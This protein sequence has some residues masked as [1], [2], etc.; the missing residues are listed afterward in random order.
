MSRFAK[1]FVA[2]LTAF[3]VVVS[4]PGLRSI[5]FGSN[6]HALTTA[7]V[8]GVDQPVSGNFDSAAQSVTFDLVSSPTNGTVNFDA[9]SGDFTY[10]PTSGFIGTDTFLFSET[11]SDPSVAPVTGDV[12]IDVLPAPTAIPGALSASPG[13]TVFSASLTTSGSFGSGVNL[14][15]CLVDPVTN[16]CGTSVAL[17]DATYSLDNSTG[18]VT[19][20][21]SPLATFG[22]L[23]DVTYIVTDAAG[24]SATSVISVTV[25]PQVS[26]LASSLAVDDATSGGVNSSQSVDVLTND[27]AANGA[28]PF[29]ASTLRLCDTGEAPPT[30][31]AVALTTSGGDFVV[32][33]STVTFT[34]VADFVG[35]VSVSYQ[36]ADALG[37]TVNATL[38]AHVV[39]PVA[40]HALGQSIAVLS[41]SSGDF[42]P[43][44]G[45]GGLA[46]GTSLTACLVSLVD[47]SCVTSVTVAQG[48]YS[49]N[50]SSNVVTFTASPVAPAGSAAPVT[51]RVTDSLGQSVNASLSAVVV[52]PLMVPPLV[53][54]SAPGTSVVFHPL[55]TITASNL[56]PLDVSSLRLC[57]ASAQ[58]PNC[59]NTSVTTSAGTFV[60]GAGGAITFT[61]A[62]NFSGTS[63]AV[64]YQVFDALGQMGA[65]TLTVTEQ[66]GITRSPSVRPAG[67]TSHG[68]LA[69]TGSPL[70]H[71]LLLSAALIA[72]GTVLRIIT[73]RRS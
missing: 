30:C 10:T 70:G 27:V 6:A 59:T 49:L 62:A 26:T 53:I 1:T 40:P 54:N 50:T 52:L 32:N 22:A 25:T 23:A 15:A 4:V 7:L 24:Q 51:Y 47:S 5:V 20:A 2:F 9:V 64:T 63:E 69:F 57:A 61:P 44:I 13:D 46:T 42:A 17:T 31:T 43:L 48:T 3:V 67:Y 29:D 28:G 66:R 55:A 56:D 12:T 39:A 35:D 11:G 8:T 58:A 68:H 16:T 36:V 34:P 41:A 71:T 19:V 60:V 37:T 65:A 45:A 18:V 21:V 73:R 38:I 33:G 72:L 14:S